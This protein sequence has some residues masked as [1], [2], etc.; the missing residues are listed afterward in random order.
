MPERIRM[1]LIGVALGAAWGAILALLAALTG[2]VTAASVAFSV[3]TCGM[4]GGGIAALF[5]AFRVARRGE[6][7]MPRSPYRRY[8]RKGN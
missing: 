3:L 8:K 1:V 4:I 6:K 7:I 5:G 2:S